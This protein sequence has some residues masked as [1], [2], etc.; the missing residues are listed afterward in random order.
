MKLPAF[1]F[2]PADWRKDPGVQALSF[3]DRGVW[4]EILCLMHECS[5][6][7]KLLLNGQPMPEDALARLLG[8]DKQIL[9]KTLTTLLAFGVASTDGETGALVS[10]RMVR[11]EEI[12]V[13]RQKAGR[14]GGNPGLLNQKFNQNQTA[15]LKQ[16]Q[17]PSSSSSTS[18]DIEKREGFKVPTV[19]EV[20]G[21]AREM[22]MGKPDAEMF[23]HFYESKGWHVGKNRMKSWHSALVGWHARAKGAKGAAATETRHAP[24][25]KADGPRATPEQIATLRREMANSNE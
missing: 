15:L 13:I 7:G 5:Q 1:Q 11:D 3:H 10:R 20:V 25:P 21:K 9:T 19:E 2:Y 14:M 16:N 6:R 12:R 23:W 18:V 17:T 22:G 24:E 4:F 8:L